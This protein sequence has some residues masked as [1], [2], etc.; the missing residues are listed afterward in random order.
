MDQD[1]GMFGK[2]SPRMAAWLAW[3]FWA[4]AIGFSMAS[5]LVRQTPNSW[6]NATFVA[7]ATT[8]AVIAWRLRANPIGWLYLGMGFLGALTTFAQQYAMRGLVDH[9]GSLPGAVYGAWLEQ[10]SLWFV[11]P[12]GIALV[13][14]LFPTGRPASPRWRP[15][16]W[17]SITSALLMVVGSMFAPGPM[18][19]ALRPASGPGVNFGVQNPVGID[20]LRAALQLADAAGRAGAFLLILIAAVGLVIRFIRGRGDERQQLK[21]V[22]YVGSA[23]SL[24]ILGMI[25]LS[26]SPQLQDFAF[27]VV[28][29]G[30]IIGLPAATAIAV[31]KYRLYDIDI[32][33]NKSLVYGALAVFI[34]VVYVAIVVGI[35]SLV[36][37]GGRP[38][39]GLSIL[40][41]A[42]VA[43]AF[44]PVR[45]RVQRVANR[46]VYGKRASPYE[47]LSQFSQRVADVYSTE[48]VLP[49]MARVLGEG[50]GALRADVW[51]LL[52]DAIAPAASWPIGNGPAPAPVD[53]SERLPASVP[54]VS[55]IVPVMHQGDLLGGVSISKQPG[56]TL[57]PV[58]EKLLTDLA[59]QAGLMLRNVRLTAELQARLTEISRQA[60]ELRASRQRIVAAQDAERRRL[61]RNIHDGA[62]Q[63]LVALTV[64]LRLATN[65]AKRDPERARDSVKALKDE[66]DQALATLRALARGIYP[67]L[68]RE[69]GLVAAVRAEAE[70]MAVPARV[71]ADDIDRYA[72]DIEAAIYFVCLEALQNVTKHAMASH[73]QIT[74]HSRK[75]ALSFDITDDGAGFDVTKDA[76]GS[77]LRNMT[78]R[79]DAIG[80]RLEIRSA[81][82]GTT[83]SGVIPIRAMEP[84]G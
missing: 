40:A 77:G 8:G 16:I 63:N 58:E 47:V 69:Q 31:L 25:V 53:I 84:V 54:G 38:N 42:L 60:V 82:R 6:F 33:I 30:F 11:F 41:T 15:L 37:T 1:R 18:S 22:A 10:W 34:T 17:I 49:Q 2:L 27:G 56:E 59:G 24:G 9:P 71:V 26:P 61:E 12:A 48:D 75:T 66:S 14:F 78:D 79:I 64:K 13:L 20:G 67:P 73:V 29:A 80:G 55:Q 36:G 21:W 62:Q 65:L 7:L 70:K 5:P 52:G 3:S 35:G 74:L 83:V 44:E 19:D 45:E 46:L 72:P 68:L 50:T 39:L 57:T 4:L 43:I 76:K 51:L 81:A 32:V 23:V 28:L